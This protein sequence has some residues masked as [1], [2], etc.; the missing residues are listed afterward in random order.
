MPD[1]LLEPRCG[2]HHNTSP[3][4]NPVL[5][6]YEHLSRACRYVSTQQ[7]GA[8][9]HHNKTRHS[10]FTQYQSRLEL[11]PQQKHK[12]RPKNFTHQLTSE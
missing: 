6:F 8:A 1:R 10:S 2:T 12:R 9:L 11:H 4:I 3:T 5:L 7:A